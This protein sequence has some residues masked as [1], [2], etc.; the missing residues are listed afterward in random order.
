MRQSRVVLQHVQDLPLDVGI[1]VDLKVHA[2]A[3]VDALAVR[4]VIE[5]HFLQKML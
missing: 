2:F 5:V 4:F 1:F 3:V